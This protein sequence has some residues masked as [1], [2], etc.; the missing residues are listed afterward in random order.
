MPAG[1]GGGAALDLAALAREPEALR[2]PLPARPCP[3]ARGADALVERR[4]IEGIARLIAVRDDA[5][6]VTLKGGW[7]VVRGG[8]RLRLRRR[9]APHVCDPVC[10]ASAGVRGEPAA[11]AQVRFCGRLYTAELV[12]GA[13][14]PS[15][16]G[17][18]VLA[19]G[20]PDSTAPARL[21]AFVGLE[22]VPARVTLRHPASGDRFTP[23]GMDRETTLARLSRGGAGRA[24]G[25][26]P[27]HRPRRR[28]RRCLGGLRGR[29]RQTIG[30]GAHPLRVTESTLCTLHVVEEEG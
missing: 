22:A 20:A 10:S 6:S 12:E 27:R 11:A 3:R 8:G 23:F 19:P 7:D 16:K 24:A 2:A 13:V 21:E 9:V 1:T 30:E 4:E 25:P 28:R 15:V 26:R 18:G 14:A 17:G 29:R 5:G